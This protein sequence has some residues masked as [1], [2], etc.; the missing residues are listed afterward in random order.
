MLK[1]NKTHCSSPRNGLQM[2][3]VPLRPQLESEHFATLAW[4][5]HYL[6]VNVTEIAV[7]CRRFHDSQWQRVSRLQRCYFRRTN[8]MDGHKGKQ[9][10][11]NLKMVYLFFS[12]SQICSN[13]GED[14]IRC[15]KCEARL[16]KFSWQG[17]IACSCGA[18]MT[19]GFLLSLH[20]LDK[21]T[22]HKEVEAVIWLYLSMKPEP[23]IHLW[24][25]H[26]V[27]L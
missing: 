23:E 27:I 25:W 4:R 18:T 12:C 10:S 26:S 22:M 24:L 6:V 9:I 13:L 15:A 14:T 8:E 20:R 17:K 7:H 16:G 2:Q 1:T 3:T 21:C 5:S 11:N 19:P